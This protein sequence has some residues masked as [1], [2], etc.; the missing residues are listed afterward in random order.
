MD[1]E[2]Q[3]NLKQQYL[4]L[5]PEVRTAIDDIDLPNKLQQVASNNKIMLD[6]AG[7]LEIE[8][9]LV[10]FG[11]EPLD[12]YVNNLVKNVGLPKNQA[13]IVAHDV[14]ELIFKSVREAL[15]KINEETIKTENKEVAPNEPTKDEIISRIEQ[16][17]IIKHKEDSISVSSL[18]SNTGIS[19]SPTEFI[20]RGV[21]IRK[22]I[23]PEIEPM[24]ILPKTTIVGQIN[25]SSSPI[26]NIVKSKMESPVIVPKKIVIMEEK[27]K[28]PTKTS[29]DPYREAIQ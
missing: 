19:S 27:T 21:E 29:T 10:L 6:Q 20:S 13:L 23:L 5:P 28:L 2:I 8:T 17:D 4:A 1:E 11:L 14:D 26:E 12:D 16:P 18:K 25:T 22:E 15:K 3:N 9:T 24:A 7:A